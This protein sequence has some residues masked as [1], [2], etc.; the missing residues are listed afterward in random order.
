[1]ADHLKRSTLRPLRLRAERE[2]LRAPQVVNLTP[3]QE[4]DRDRRPDRDDRSF[5]RQLS[6]TALVAS[7]NE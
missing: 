4:E 1:M 6:Y 2:L 3:E 7:V 5:V